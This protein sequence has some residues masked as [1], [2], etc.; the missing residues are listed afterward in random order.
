MYQAAIQTQST[1]ILAWFDAT[2]LSVPGPVASWPGRAGGTATPPSANNRPTFSLNGL[3][4]RP[5]VVFDGV[6]DC[7]EFPAVTGTYWSAFLVLRR[8]QSP[9]YGTV[10]QATSPTAEWAVVAL[11]NDAITGPIQVTSGATTR[12]GGTYG[13]A[14]PR[15]VSASFSASGI[16]FKESGVPAVGITTSTTGY[17][18]LP[19]ISLI[20]AARMSPSL[21]GRFFAGAISEIRVYGSISASQESAIYRELANKWGVA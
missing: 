4:G 18:Y 3:S 17:T 2:Q 6:N 13:A 8:D 14:A 12:S 7:L 21:L 20:G 9:T 15:I 10:L 16:D 1:G 19:G 11:N 5:T